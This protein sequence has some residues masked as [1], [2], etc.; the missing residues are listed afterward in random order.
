[1]SSFHLFSRKKCNFRHFFTKKCT[2]RRNPSGTPPKGGS[3]RGGYPPLKGVPKPPQKCPFWTPYPRKL[4]SGYVKNFWPFK[5]RNSHFG[6]ASF[7]LAVLQ[8]NEQSPGPPKRGPGGVFL[9][10]IRMRGPP[11]PLGGWGGGL[12]PPGGTPPVPGAKKY[13]LFRK[14][15][16]KTSF[17]SKNFANFCENI[18]IFL[19]KLVTTPIRHKVCL[20]GGKRAFHP[21]MQARDTFRP[22]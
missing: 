18:A 21:E 12:A 11:K 9:I 20:G 19:R 10:P 17:F 15:M 6:L 13:P 1:L 5:P 14:K 8:A 4:F 22:T 16:T 7:V 3:G 2:F